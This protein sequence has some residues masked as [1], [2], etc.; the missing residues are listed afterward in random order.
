VFFFYV[1]NALE[2]ISV[3]PQNHDFPREKLFFQY[4]QKKIKENNKINIYAL[5]KIV[6]TEN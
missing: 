5:R 4:E 2:K 1:E 3:K 6:Y